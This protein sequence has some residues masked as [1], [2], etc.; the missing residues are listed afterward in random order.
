MWICWKLTQEKQNCLSHQEIRI[1]QSWLYEQATS[2]PHCN[3]FVV[4]D[5]FIWLTLLEYL[6]LNGFVVMVFT[7][8]IRFFLLAKLLSFLTTGYTGKYRLVAKDFLANGTAAITIRTFHSDYQ[9]IAR[10][11][12]WYN[13]VMEILRNDLQQIRRT[14]DQQ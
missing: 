11:I 9:A 3:S 12:K 6:R 1:E 2:L 5:S 8:S 4:R 10:M 13:S 7:F 14:S